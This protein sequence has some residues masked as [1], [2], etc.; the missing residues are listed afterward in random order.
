MDIRG[1]DKPEIL[2]VFLGKCSLLARSKPQSDEYKNK[3][4]ERFPSRHFYIPR[5]S[6]IQQES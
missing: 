2:S 6:L 1:K 5:F 4:N 3:G